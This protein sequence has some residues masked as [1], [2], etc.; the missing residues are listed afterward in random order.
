MHA[1]L[2]GGAAAVVPGRQE[3]RQHGPGEQIQRSHQDVE[4]RYRVRSQ[5]VHVIST[6]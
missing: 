4:T 3:H 1:S 2:G 5:P 6:S